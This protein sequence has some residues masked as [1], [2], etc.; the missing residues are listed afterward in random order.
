M[1]KKTL[2]LSKIL[3]ILLVSLWIAPNVGATTI[4]FDGISGPTSSPY[5][6]SGFSFSN[7]YNFTGPFAGNMVGP[8]AFPTTTTVTAVGGSLF[9]VSSIF[10]D[11]INSAIGS[12]TITFTGF[13]DAGGSISQN[14]TTVAGIN[15]QLVSLVGFNSLSSFTMTHPFTTFDD[16]VVEAVPIL[17]RSGY[18]ALVLSV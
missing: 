8:N 4:T 3:G 9:N 15:K 17:Q 14:F 6:E 16:M 2:A 13:L 5:V 11:E 10:V 18:S 7:P 1:V 12:K